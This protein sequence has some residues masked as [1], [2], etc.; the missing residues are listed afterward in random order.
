MRL[1][2]PILLAL[3]LPFLCTQPCIAEDGI[4]ARADERGHLALLIGNAKYSSDPQV[5]R[6]LPDLKNPCNDVMLLSGRLQLMGWKE[7]EITFRCDLE[8]AAIDA[9]IDRFV[10]SFEESP[11]SLA[12]FYFSG[13]GAQINEHNLIFGVHSRPDVGKAAEIFARMPS[14]QPFMRDAEDVAQKVANNFGDMT[15]GALLIVLDAC[16]DNPLMDDLASI[17]KIRVSA[18]QHVKIPLGIEMAF[19]TS[20]G[21]YASDGLGETGPF[22]YSLSRHMKSGMS[23]ESILNLAAVDLY[24]DTRGRRWEQKPD[25]H[26]FFLETPPHPC[27]AGCGKPIPR[28]AI[29]P[30]RHPLARQGIPQKGSN[31]LQK[32]DYNESRSTDY[33]DT[34]AFVPMQLVEGPAA[35]IPSPSTGPA[36]SAKSPR[37]LFESTQTET[38][39]DPRGGVPSINVD[40]FWCDGGGD[41]FGRHLV[42]SEVAA[43][44]ATLARLPP[45]TKGTASIHKVRVR[46]LPSDVNQRADYGYQSNVLVYD[47]TDSGSATWAKRIAEVSSAKLELRP[48]RGSSPQYMSIFLCT[49]ADPLAKPGRVYVQLASHQ[50]EGAAKD[51]I[52]TVKASSLNVG[53]AEGLDFQPKNSPNA[54]EVRIYDDADTSTAQE[55]AN[56]I[57]EATGGP[58]AVKNLKSF[59]RRGP[60][61]TFEVWFG[62]NYTPSKQ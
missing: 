9:E 61:R 46:D 41:A 25:R 58:V 32:V 2:N 17:G 14:A 21:A 3:A 24:T 23:V 18:P 50:Q 26:G 5:E 4:G 16:R 59:V 31:W 36:P 42:A 60:K 34:R 1:V 39:S 8:K 54:T 11:D 33:A 57:A 28:S 45:L 62:K 40:V 37:V 48:G 27:F 29:V 12:I 47:P 6:E 53:V 52:Q 19:S 55:L 7:E 51:F 49:D 38:N 22:A 56:L 30:E 20:D 10:Q 35:S 15:S 43:A 44:T 13:H